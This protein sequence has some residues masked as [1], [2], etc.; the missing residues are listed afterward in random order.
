MR[1][2]PVAVVAALL[3]AG[4]EKGE[5]LTVA[6]AAVLPEGW[7]LVASS[8]DGVSVGVPSGW[9]QGV[10][11]MFDLPSLDGGDSSQNPEVQQMMEQFEKTD[12]Q[13]EANS[14]ER[15]R[16]KGILCHCINGS[17]P[18]VGETPTRFYISV[19]KPGGALS[20]KSAVA[21]EKRKI[22]GA[23][24]G[25]PVQLANGNGWRLAST[26]KTRGG[27]DFTKIVYILVHE[28]RKYTLRF[29]STNDPV[30]IEG[31][32]KAVAETW[33]I[34]PLKSPAFAQN[35]D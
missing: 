31:I 29:T 5:K 15:L 21:L 24:D 28:D 7:T 2:V 23:G 32:E 11:K 33:R 14:L 17:K 6:P 27:D 20:L 4:C 13:E 8:A 18:I 10:P 19:E 34:D 1:F 3:V 9:R 25:T 35:V 22:M 16:S 26:S 12:Q 30:S